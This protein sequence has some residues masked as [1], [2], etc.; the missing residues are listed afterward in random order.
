MALGQGEKPLPLCAVLD[1]DGVSTFV[2]PE[3]LE[4]LKPPI[5]T[6]AGAAEAYREY[7]RQNQTSGAVLMRPAETTAGEWFEA[8]VCHCDHAYDETAYIVTF[9]YVAQDGEVHF[10]P[11]LIK[12]TDDFLIDR[13]YDPQPL[14]SR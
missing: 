7:V 6:Q 14:D 11:R 13:P 4:Q 5:P 10:W 2:K 12:K 3:A 1:S 8:I 9:P